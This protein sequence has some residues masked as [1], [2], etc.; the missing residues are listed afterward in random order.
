MC[1]DFTLLD[2]FDSERHTTDPPIH[3]T[4]TILGPYRYDILHSVMNNH[5][6]PSFPTHIH[7][8]SGGALQAAITILGDKHFRMIVAEN[9]KVNIMDPL[10]DPAQ[11]PSTLM[12]TITTWSTENS[13]TIEHLHTDVQHETVNCGYWV[14]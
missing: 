5:E 11:Y 1:D 6:R 14:L 7:Q 12:Q 3:G 9:S 8:A 10:Y 2:I 13:H 4:S